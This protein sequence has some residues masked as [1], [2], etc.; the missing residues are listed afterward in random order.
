ML[1]SIFIDDA[2]IVTALIQQHLISTSDQNE[3]YVKILFSFYSNVLEENTI[4]TIWAETFDFHKGLYKINNIPFYASF[5]MGDIVFAEFDE[6][7]QMLT[8]RETVEYSGNSTIQVVIMD[9]CLS[10][11][12]LRGLFDSKGCAT[13][14]LNESYFV[15]DV[16]ANEDY[17]IIKNEL[18]LLGDKGIIGYAEPCLS[19][20]HWIY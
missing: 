15:V 8:Y 7:E 5:A 14:Q 9:K 2:D 1:N 3:N 10:I 6:D 4:E 11:D 16:P 18:R 17:K 12:E 20:N 19:Q 13:E